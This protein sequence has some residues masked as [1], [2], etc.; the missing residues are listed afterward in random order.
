MSHKMF[1]QYGSIPEFVGDMGGNMDEKMFS[2]N[3]IF[4]LTGQMLSMFGN[5]MIRFAISLYILDLTK[6]SAVYGT[7]TAISYLPSVLLSPLGGVLADRGNKKRWM[8]LLDGSYCMVTLV[9]GIIFQRRGSLILVC[10]LLIILAVLSSFEAPVSSAC[11]P[12]ISDGRD[13]TRANAASNQVS[14][15]SGLLAPF[16]SGFLYGITGRNRFYELMYLCAGCFLLAAGIEVLIKI[17]EQKLKSYDT[18][19][20]VIRF[21]LAD[22]FRLVFKDRKYI[23]ETMLLNGLLTFLVT[24]YL[25]IGMNYLISVKLRLPA[26]WNGGAQMAAAAAVILGSVVAAAISEKFQTKNLYKFLT[27]MGASFVFLIPALYAGFPPKAAF[28][29]VCFTSVA[30]LLL[31]NAAGVFIISGMQ[32]ACPQSMLGRLMA[33]FHACNNL[34][35]PIGIWMHG[36]IYEKYDDKLYAVFGVIAVLTVFMAVRGKKVYSQ[37][38]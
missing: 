19:M 3:L 8:V 34:I 22:V 17:P 21:D 31:A 29:I 30:I 37:L 20:K 13:L 16:L 7:V 33:L 14:A 4:L 5:S 2:G 10:T 15:L 6:S 25:S 24:P 32:K 23:G 12:L 18:I 27:A 1:C 35:L 36:I 9:M 11:I 26:V 38:P 28:C